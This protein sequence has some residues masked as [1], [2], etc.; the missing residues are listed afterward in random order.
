MLTSWVFC[1]V[2]PQLTAY[3]RPVW[4]F[5]F[6]KPVLNL[7]KTI[8]SVLQSPCWPFAQ[9]QFESQY[10][11]TEPVLT[12]C[13]RPVWV[14]L[15]FGEPVLA[16]CLRPVWVFCFAE[17]VLTLHKTS[18]SVLFCWASVDLLLKTSLSVLFYWASV[19]LLLKTR[20]RNIF[21][22]TLALHHNKYLHI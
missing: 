13:S 18:L 3:S 5:C 22:Y 12:S 21:K 20:P 17:V 11:F 8:S 6:A 7:L 14:L 15:F 1:F 10:Y 2:E 9:N 19:G 16:S 4:V